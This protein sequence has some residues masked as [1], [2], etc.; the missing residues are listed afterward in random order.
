VSENPDLAESKIVL[1]NTAEEKNEDSN[2]SFEVT[3]TQIGN[4]TYQVVSNYIGKISL[5]D[6]VKNAIRRDIESGNY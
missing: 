4:T 1:A 6:I 3:Y 5:L 2:D